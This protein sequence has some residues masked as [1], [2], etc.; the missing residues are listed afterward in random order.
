[1][2]K[3]RF[4]LSV[5][6]DTNDYQIEQVHAA[7]QAAARVPADLDIVY[8]QDD[9]IMQSQQLLDRIQSTAGPRPNAIIFE[10]AGSTTL[11]QVAR[12]AAAA[13]IGWVVLSR[14]ADYIKTFRSNYSI[15][16]FVVTADHVEIGRIQ[17]RQLAALLPHGGIVLYIHGPAQSEAAKLRHMGLMATKPENIQ[18]RIMKAHWSE[19]S[20][21]K[22]VRSWLELP[23]SRGTEIAAVCAQDDA[24]AMGARKAFEEAAYGS[25]AWQQIPFLGCDGMPDTG[26]EWVRRGLLTS[27]VLSPPTAP[28]AIDLLA[29][30]LHKGEMPPECTL[31]QTKSIPHLDALAH[32]ARAAAR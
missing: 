14:D 17:G 7:R 30:F 4:L 19:V 20:A 5:T 32:K 3:A 24:M 26:Q 25:A 15:P 9:G 22:I 28:V 2:N 1:M 16:A 13:G 12:V 21:H 11:P 27:T 10:P 29:R 18:L 31:T 23:T 6:N 8:A